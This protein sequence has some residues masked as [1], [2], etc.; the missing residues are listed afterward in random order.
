[1]DPWR[2]QQWRQQLEAQREM[3]RVKERGEGGIIHP[4]IVS[5]HTYVT[6]SLCIINT[7]F[8]NDGVSPTLR[9]SQGSPIMAFILGPVTSGVSPAPLPTMP[10]WGP[11]R[12]RCCKSEHVRL[13]ATH[14]PSTTQAR[15]TLR[16]QVCM[17][18]FVLDM[19]CF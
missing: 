12:V 3:V 5:C 19:F 13:P 2:Q 18:Y 7:S 4:L 14:P 16:A 10:P 6:A 8:L 1:M 17:A 15:I 11:I 9:I